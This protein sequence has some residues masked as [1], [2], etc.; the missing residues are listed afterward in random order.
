MI[1]TT[2]L[3]QNLDKAFDRRFLYKI[4]FEKPSALAKR[5]IWK[6][7]IPSI[8][9]S[10]AEVLSQNYDFSGG[11]IEN[12]ARK[13]LVESILCGSE[14]TLGTLHS[15]CQSEVLTKTNSAGG[16]IGYTGR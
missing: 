5:E 1:A 13:R 15:I 9:D 14:P 8:C 6:V 10:D 16:K 2:N 3:S 11:Q 7:M 4:E 12:I